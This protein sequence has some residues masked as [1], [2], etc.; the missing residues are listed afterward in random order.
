M[1]IT[2]VAMTAIDTRML[3]RELK[4]G[5]AE[6]IILSIVEPRAAP[7]LRDQQ[8]HRGALGRAAEVPRRVALS[9]ALPARRTRLAA[10]P[11]GREGRAAPPPLLPPDGRGP[12][13]P[14][15]AA[16][17]LEGLRRTP[18]ASSPESIMPE[19]DRAPAPATGRAPP[20][21]GPRGRDHRRA[22]AASRRALRRAAR[23]RRERRRARA[24]WRSRNCS[25]PTR[26]RA[27]CGRCA[28]RSVPPPDHAGSA[29]AA[30][31]R[32][33][34]AGRALRRAHAAQAAGLR[35]RGHPDARARHRRQHRDLQPRQRHAAA[36]AAGRQPRPPRLRAPRQRRRR[37]LLSDVRGA[38]RRQPRVRR[39]RGV[40]RHHRQPE[41]RRRDRARHRRRSSPATSSTCSASRR[42]GTAALD[43]PTM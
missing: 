12:P 40:G 14:R 16:R 36:A 41:R 23:R 26:S 4:K 15:P 22:V 11:V 20:E 43:R 17:Y 25:S 7:W 33:S 28:R 9:A 24:A 30:P 2:Y 27:T 29:A 19:L 8:A 42:A 32:R 18:W 21:P 3:D 38:A 1:A 31:A 6:L 10:G 34:L 37:V 35:R 13:R 5:S 39:I